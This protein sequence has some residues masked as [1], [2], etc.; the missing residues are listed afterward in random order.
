LPE[1]L[2]LAI[3]H[4]ESVARVFIGVRN[5]KIFAFGPHPNDFYACNAPIA[6]LYDLGVEVM[7]NSELDLIQL[8]QAIPENDPEVAKTALSMGRELGEGNRY[9]AM[10]PKLTRFPRAYRQAAAGFFCGFPYIRWL[11]FGVST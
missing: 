4:F 1:E 8:Y 2:A 9:P 7:E 10:L 11:S 6:P 3:K 5:L